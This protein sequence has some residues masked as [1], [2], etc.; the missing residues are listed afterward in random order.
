MCWGLWIYPFNWLVVCVVLV[1]FGLVCVWKPRRAS[2]CSC[3]YLCRLVKLWFRIKYLFGSGTPRNQ[4][5]P[6][7]STTT[8]AP[9]TLRPASSAANGLSAANTALVAIPVVIAVGCCFGCVAWCKIKSGWVLFMLNGWKQSRTTSFRRWEARCSRQQLENKVSVT[10]ILFGGHFQWFLCYFYYDY[11]QIYYTDIFYGSSV[12]SVVS[13]SSGAH[14]KKA[15]VLL[16]CTMYI[17][18]KTQPCFLLTYPPGNSKHVGSQLADVYI[19][20]LMPRRNSQNLVL[21]YLIRFFH[22]PWASFFK[23]PESF[24]SWNLLFGS[25]V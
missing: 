7:S 12:F 1:W 18:V 5:V 4:V 21:L 19:A 24:K 9:P 11:L 16:G 13:S 10:L 14:R 15:N 23:L 22:L 2:P 6:R 3:F 25:L 20:Y 8:I 17:W